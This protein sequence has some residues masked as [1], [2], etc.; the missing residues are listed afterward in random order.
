MSKG[1]NCYSMLNVK[2]FRRA[3]GQDGAS[4]YPLHKASRSQDG[5]SAYP[6]HK[7][8]RSQDGASAPTRH[9]H[10]PRPYT[11]GIKH[12]LIGGTH[13]LAMGA[14]NRPLRVPIWLSGGGSGI[15]Q[16]YAPD[17]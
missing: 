13:G 14:M 6:L 5:A 7:A 3:E 15:P 11:W 17:T 1:S 16:V 4:A 10:S 2:D 12:S 9:P 8:S